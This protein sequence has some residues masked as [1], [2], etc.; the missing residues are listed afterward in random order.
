MVPEAFLGMNRL[1]A[2][3]IR[4]PATMASVLTTVPSIGFYR[5]LINMRDVRYILIFAGVHPDCPGNF[6]RSSQLQESHFRR[7]LKKTTLD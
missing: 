3:P 6:K 7:T 1:K 2:R 5:P 4:L